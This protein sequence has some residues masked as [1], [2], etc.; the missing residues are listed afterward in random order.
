MKPSS[1]VTVVSTTSV[2]DVSTR[3]LHVIILLRL[4]LIGYVPRVCYLYLFRLR[5]I[6][7]SAGVLAKK[8]HFYDNANS[9]RNGFCLQI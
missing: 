1:V 9:V 8:S 7:A 2:L 4:D 3:I 6:F 5:I